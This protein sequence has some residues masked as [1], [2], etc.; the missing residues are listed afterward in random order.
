MAVN[1][2]FRTCPTTGLVFHEPADKLMR[3]TPSPRWCRCSS[4]AC[5]RSAGH[6]HPLAGRAPAAARLFYLVLTAHGLNMLVFWI[7]FFEIAVLYF[8]AST[9]LGAASP[10]RRWPGSGSG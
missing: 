2:M 10:R 1:R 5:S 6:A 7:I 8:A 9:L 4:A 3:R